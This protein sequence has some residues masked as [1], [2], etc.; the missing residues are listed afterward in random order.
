MTSM[1]T[2]GDWAQAFDDFESREAVVLLT[3]HRSKGLEFHTMIFLGMDD[4]QWW[5]YDREVGEATSTFFV[6]LSRAAQRLLFTSTAWALVKARSLICS[7]VGRCESI[8][9]PFGL[10]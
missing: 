7:L 1:L 6:G 8:G 9:D 3:I 2:A 5:A 4:D 10:S